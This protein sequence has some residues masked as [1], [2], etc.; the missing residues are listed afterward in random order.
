MVDTNAAKER[1][2][3]A[4]LD[5]TCSCS[6]CSAKKSFS[7]SRPP[8]LI[9]V[10]SAPEEG[11]PLTSFSRDR[12]L[13]PVPEEPTNPNESAWA[14]DV[15]TS[16]VSEEATRVRPGD[17]LVAAVAAA[18][19]TNMNTSASYQHFAERSDVGNIGVFLCNWGIAAIKKKS[20]VYI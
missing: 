2:A 9:S 7:S 11:F 10:R 16:L 3:V 12:T 1:A 20:P 8:Q 18:S 19:P 5:S 6:A 17:Y 14:H 4:A 13:L 15:P